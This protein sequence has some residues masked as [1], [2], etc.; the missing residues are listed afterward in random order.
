MKKILVC[1][2]ERKRQ[3]NYKIIRGWLVNAIRDKKVQK[4]QQKWIKSYFEAPCPH[5][6][7]PHTQC[8]LW[9]VQKSNT[10][11]CPLLFR[12]LPSGKTGLCPGMIL[13]LFADRLESYMHSS[14][15]GHREGSMVSHRAPEEPKAGQNLPIS[16][17]LQQNMYADFSISQEYLH[18]SSLT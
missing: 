12:D 18:L 11:A 14:L 15:R 1:W 16:P 13:W 4:I 5:M 17:L 10:A 3:D 9:F 7:I 8:F 6:R 2:G